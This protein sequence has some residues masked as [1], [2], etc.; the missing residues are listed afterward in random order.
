[1]LKRLLTAVLLL[2]IFMVFTGTAFSGTKNVPGGGDGDVL[3]P[4]HPTAPSAKEKAPAFKTMATPEPVG[5]ATLL[6]QRPHHAGAM[7]AD[8]MTCGQADYFSPLASFFFTFARRSNS[9]GSREF[10]MRFDGPPPSPGYKVK[11]NGAYNWIYRIAEGG[12]V[13]GVAKIRVNVYNDAVGSPG[14]L[15]Y[16]EVFSAPAHANTFN[17]TWFPFTTPPLLT[18]SYHISFVVDASSPSTDTVVFTSDDAGGAGG[19][20]VSANRGNVESAAT[21][22]VWYTPLAIFGG[23]SAFDFSQVSDFCNVY[24]SCYTAAT[25]SNGSVSLFL[26][27]DPAWTSGSTLYGFGQRFVSA[28]PDTVK[29]VDFQHYDYSLTYGAG[30]F[31]PL[32]GTN[33]L[34]VKI[35]G[36]DG[37]GNVDYGAGALATQTVP[38]GLASLF[39][40]TGGNGTANGWNHLI[41]TFPTPPVVFGPWHVTVEMT[42]TNDADGILLTP[43]NSSG[44]DPGRVG[45]SVAFTAPDPTWIRTGSSPSWTLDG[46]G[47]RAFYIHVNLCHDEF[48]VCTNEL[49]YLFGTTRF[50]YMDSCGSVGGV[51][52]RSGIASMMQGGIGGPNRVEKIRFQWI[53][54]ANFDAVPDWPNQLKVSVFADA[55]GNVGPAIWSTIVTPGAAEQYPGWTEVVIPGGVIVAGDFFV[56]VE[57][58]FTGDGNNEWVYFG[59]ERVGDDPSI[60]ALVRGGMHVKLCSDGLW[61]QNIAIGGANDNAIMEAE[62]CSVPPT[63]ITCGPADNFATTLH[64]QGRTGHSNVSLSDA[65]N[66]L[67]VA[68]AYNDVNFGT[69]NGAMASAA[70]I[71]WNNYVVCE[72]GTR[73]VILDATTGALLRTITGSGAPDFISSTGS[74]NCTPTIANVII[75]GT[76]T[77]VLFVAGGSVPSIS[78]YNMDVA[79]IPQIWSINSTTLAAHGFPGAIGNSSYA[80]FIKLTLAGNERLFFA[81]SGP[82]L[83]SVDA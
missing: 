8:T 55:G 29:S 81:T 79:G 35:W 62:F 34:I 74:L 57:P 13:D 46:L 10:A 22:G 75:S 15:A 4:K 33:G 48:S 1:M 49:S 66:D 67:T 59:R 54:E 70:P 9:A 43:L 6:S 78:A 30:A 25:P 36:D 7:G 18:G 14:T 20:G 71:V 45:G 38:G 80:N 52:S 44:A 40:T 72:F 12:A 61:H 21:P 39:P 42:S 63:E 50:L 64:D 26:I 51:G 58:Q 28:G 65:Y 37:T 82:R 41:V 73:Y 5:T 2:A 47:E 69:I 53:D 60:T 16:S 83:Y 77:N 31:Y 56:G 11:V 19:T 23:T 17:Y 27:P 3:L 76:P 24:S 68:W 32:A